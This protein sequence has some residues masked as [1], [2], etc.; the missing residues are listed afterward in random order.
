MAARKQ[1]QRFEGPM[2]IYEVH[3]GSW[4]RK[5]DPIGMRWLS[6]RELAERLVPYAREMGYTHMELLPIA[7]HPYD[8]SWGY[9]TTGYFAPTSRYGSPDDPSAQ[10]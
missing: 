2:S 3:L 1:R 6:Y 4:R 7:E 10:I 8:G 5:L 9:E